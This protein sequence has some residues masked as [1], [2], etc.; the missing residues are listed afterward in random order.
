MRDDEEEEEMKQGRKGDER[1]LRDKT[2]EGDNEKEKTGGGLE[3][4]GRRKEW[5]KKQQKGEKDVQ[6]QR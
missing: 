5:R 6:R 4:N 3:R 1:N 2:R